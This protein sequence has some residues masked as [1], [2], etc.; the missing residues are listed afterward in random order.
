MRYYLL[1]FVHLTTTPHGGIIQHCMVMLQNPAESS[2][3]TPD[4]MKM[5]HCGTI[6]DFQC[7]NPTAC[8]CGQAAEGA[9]KYEARNG[10]SR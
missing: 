4:N 10:I 8:N 3:C 1:I 5:A 7:N 9:D 2:A 6:R